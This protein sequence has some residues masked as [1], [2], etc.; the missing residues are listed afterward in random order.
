MNG[1]TTFESNPVLG[2]F[3]SQAASAHRG[4]RREFDPVAAAPLGFVQR[5]IGG[6]QQ[7]LRR[8][9]LTARTG[10]ADADRQVVANALARLEH[11]GLDRQAQPFR[12]GGGVIRC[13]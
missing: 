10:D 7:Q 8:I 1:D 3:R 2:G 5:Q 6:V 12:R 11:H 4:H 9:D 13:V